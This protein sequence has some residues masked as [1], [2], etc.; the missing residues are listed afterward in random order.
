MITDDP[1]VVKILNAYREELG[2]KELW[3]ME[4]M[5]RRWLEIERSLKAEIEALEALVLS[6]RDAGEEVTLQVLRKKERMLQLERALREEMRKYNQEYLVKVVEAN[7]VE[8]GMLGAEAGEKA[9]RASYVRMIAPW[10]PVL[11]KSAIEA[12]AGALSLKAPLYELLKEAYPKAIDGL[13]T[14]LLNGVARGLGVNDV[15]KE[16]ARGMGAGL[17]RALLIARTEL[18]R[19]YRMGTIEQ[20]RA[21]KVVKGYKRLVKKSTACM[22]CLMLDGERYENKEDMSDHPQGKCQVVPIVRGADDPKWVTGREYFEGL[23]PEEQMARM[24]RERYEL[25]K[26][27]YFDLSALAIKQVDPVWGSEPRVATVK[28][29]L[30]VD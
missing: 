11:N 2:R 22:G 12:M 16:M 23:S 9:I 24:G 15:A 19:A 25:W 30:G 8:F 20:Y 17:D 5:G 14:A 7:K 10:F 6:M 4:D 1:D 21:S 28:E 26:D 13:M 27:G 29:L 18:N 3:V